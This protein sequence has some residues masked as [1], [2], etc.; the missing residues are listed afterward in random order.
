MSRQ[1]SE[2]EGVPSVFYRNAI[3]LNRFSNGI[4]RQIAQENI[5]VILRAVEQLKKINESKGPSYKAAR[6]RALIKQTKKTLTK[7][8]KLF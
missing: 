8:D 3:D 4:A 2:G 1:V 6:L 5:N 7:L